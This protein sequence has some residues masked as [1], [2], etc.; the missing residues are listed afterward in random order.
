MPNAVRTESG[1]IV[2]MEG[3]MPV[4]NERGTWDVIFDGE[5]IA[6]GFDSEDAAWHWIDN[7]KDQA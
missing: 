4:T 7:E 2:G 3:T 5:T 1:R 6:K